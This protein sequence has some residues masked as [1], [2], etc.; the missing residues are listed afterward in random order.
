MR[1]VKAFIKLAQMFGDDP[2]FVRWNIFG[3]EGRII[4][5]ANKLSGEQS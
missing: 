5:E 4:R 2:R 3:D 1:E